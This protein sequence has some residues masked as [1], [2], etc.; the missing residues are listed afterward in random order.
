M[1]S[2]H[3]SGCPAANWLPVRT[4]PGTIGAYGAAPGPEPTRV[5]SPMPWIWPR[6]SGGQGWPIWLLLLPPHVVSACTRPKPWKSS[7]ATDVAGRLA[8]TTLNDSPSTGRCTEGSLVPPL[9]LDPLRHVDAGD[10]GVEVAEDEQKRHL[11]RAVGG[12][13]E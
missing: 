4:P 7:C 6:W 2:I 1:K 12:A 9:R 10:P 11:K 5:S 8:L 13:H 3:S